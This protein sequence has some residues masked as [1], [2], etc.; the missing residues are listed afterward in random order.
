MPGTTAISV[1]RGEEVTL[2]FTMNPIPAAGIAG[3]TI[4]F[5]VSKVAGSPV[6]IIPAK[7]ATVTSGPLGTFS[8][9][10]DA[11]ETDTTPGTYYY[12]AWRVDA[13]NEKVLAIGT[14]NLLPVARI[15]V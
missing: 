3:W 9:S 5:T 4:H 14:F 12:D 13:E 8:V 15:P 7:V 11:D 2:E 6:K 10:L 1:Y